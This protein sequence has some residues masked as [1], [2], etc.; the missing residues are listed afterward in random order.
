VEQLIRNLKKIINDEDVRQDILLY[1]LEND[2]T[3]EQLDIQVLKKQFYKK[4]GNYKEID[5]VDF[6]GKTEGD[7]INDV[8]LSDKN[9]FNDD[10]IIEISPNREFDIQSNSIKLIKQVNKV[11]RQIKERRFWLE[12]EE[13]SAICKALGITSGNEYKRRVKNKVL[14]KI[15]P[16]NPSD[17][18]A[19]RNCWINW[20]DFLN[21][22]YLVFHKNYLKEYAEFEKYIH[23][24]LEVIGLRNY[25]DWK[26]FKANKLPVPIPDFVPRNPQNVYK[27]KGWTNWNTLFKNTNLSFSQRKGEYISY[28][29]AKSWV[30]V[31]LSFQGINNC[32][33]WEAYCRGDYGNEFKSL[34]DNIPKAPRIFYGKTKEWV[35]WGDWF[36]TGVE[37]NRGKEF[38]SYDE[39]K[40]W[41]KNQLG[42]KLS[43]L[44]FLDWVYGKMPE[45]PPKPKM[46]PNAPNSLYKDKGWINWKFFLGNERP[47]PKPKKNYHIKGRHIRIMKEGI[48]FWVKV[49]DWNKTYF[50]G[51]IETI[52]E[53]HDKFRRE[54][55]V[56]FRKSE[57]IK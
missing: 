54:A 7:F 41:L 20:N 53:G 27:N 10:E 19:N 56:K 16:A 49:I 17:F 9:S 50:T 12:Y 57:I 33:K 14:P 18:Y 28:K 8:L 29:E 52:I 31:N 38:W 36:G 21:H 15:L 13:A 6:S 46:M 3:F 32:K 55:I 40:N 30:H 5:F 39:S 48:K 45:L 44:Q 42:V 43:M 22:G 51:E 34:P 37:W 1:A 23:E 25:Q 24:N 11:S 26:K 4:Y 47:K 2:L 35:S